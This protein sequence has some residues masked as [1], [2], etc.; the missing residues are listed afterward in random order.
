MYS[1]NNFNSS[2]NF[3]V[4]P[5]LNQIHQGCM[6]RLYSDRPGQKERGRIDLDRPLLTSTSLNAVS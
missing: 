4:K 1:P 3:F 6:A 5:V 2:R